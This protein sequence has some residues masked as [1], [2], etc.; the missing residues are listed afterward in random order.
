MGAAASRPA[1]S[2]ALTST[3]PAP[4][5]VPA[6][7]VTLVAE[8]DLATTAATALRQRGLVIDVAAGAPVDGL[9]AA[10]SRGDVVGVVWHAI[11]GRA[12]A[13]ALAEPCRRAAAAGRPAV[14]LVVRDRGDAGDAVALAALRASGAVLVHDPDAWIEAVAL[15]AQHGTPRGPRVAIVAPPGS[16]LALAADAI[17]STD[18]DGSARSAPQFAAT[19]P[20]GPAD[21]ILHDAS[22]P[23]PEALRRRA[24]VLRGRFD[25]VA[26]VAG[27]PCLVGVRAALT[28]VVAAGRVGERLEVGL[29]PAPALASRELDIDRDRLERQLGKLE[30]W[31]RRIGD[32]ETKVLL[33]AYGVPTTR[34]AVATTPSAALRL[35]RRA[36]FPVELKRWGSAEPS[37][38][39]GAHVERNVGSAADVRRAFQALL[40]SASDDEAQG[41]DAVIVR[42]TPP[43]GR[44]LRA[45]ITRDREVGWV[46]LVDVPGAPATLAALAPLR[47]IDAVA[48]AAHLPSTRAGDADPDRAALANVLR[49][50]SHLAVDLADRIARLELGRIVVSPTRT[51]VVDAAIDLIAG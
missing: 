27:G 19:D 49:R 3:S 17:A 16:F 33:A 28:A 6:P 50:A 32:H 39:A 18:D 37:E 11:A 45:V 4:L 48:L 22:M 43:P 36:G 40:G 29:G 8:G 47:L 23:P 5:P 2:A 15:I 51:L 31:H 21:V 13:A 1:M 12:S 35:A 42:E 46:V 10:A 24:I 34:Q 41:D 38:G 26:S 20:A 9:S 44:E 30:G 7:Q 25:G 14:V